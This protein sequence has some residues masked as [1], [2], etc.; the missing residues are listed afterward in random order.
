[1]TLVFKSVCWNPIV[2]MES[3]GKEYREFEQKIENKVLLEMETYTKKNNLTMN[4]L[5]SRRDRW[6]KVDKVILLKIFETMKATSFVTKRSILIPGSK[7][8]KQLVQYPQSS[9]S[10]TSSRNTSSSSSSTSSSS[11]NLS[12]SNVENQNVTKAY[13]QVAQKA[14]AKPGSKQMSLI[15]KQKL[16]R[17]CQKYLLSPEEINSVFT[18]YQFK[19]NNNAFPPTSR[20]NN[21]STTQTK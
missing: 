1:M 21:V 19:K 11:S 7:F 18:L 10:S 2:E 8:N 9:S 6:R 15:E 12:L 16:F 3:K 5:E 14:R 13:P 20:S 17:I 4:E